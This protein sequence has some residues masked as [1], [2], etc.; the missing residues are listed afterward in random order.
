MFLNWK[1][2]LFVFYQL[3]KVILV[4][5]EIEIIEVKYINYLDI[6]WFIY[7]FYFVLK[8]ILGRF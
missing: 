5:E 1:R 6:Y 7:I 3:L 2:G 8:R 4:E